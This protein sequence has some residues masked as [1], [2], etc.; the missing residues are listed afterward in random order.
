[1]RVESVWSLAAS[2]Q[3]MLDLSVN[4]ITQAGG[5]ARLLCACSLCA[6]VLGLAGSELEPHASVR[7]YLEKA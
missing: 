3:S 1:M 6:C 5:G 4:L 2:R 7:T